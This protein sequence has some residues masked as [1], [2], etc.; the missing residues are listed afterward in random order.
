MKTESFSLTK[1]E[2]EIMNLL[3]IQNRP[4]SRSEIIQFSKERTWKASSIHILLNQLLKK[5]AIKVDGFIKTGKNYGRTFAAAIT[6]EEYQIIQ[7]KENFRTFSTKPSAF[8]NFVSTLVQDEEID[9]ETLDRL[10]AI[11]QAKRSNN[12]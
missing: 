4:L 12:K 6:Q 7:F 2:K 8:V 11:L 9:D 1:N 3:W 10:E 5:G